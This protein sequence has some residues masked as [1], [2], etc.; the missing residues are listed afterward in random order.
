MTRVLLA[1]LGSYLIG[2]IPTGYWLVKW[3]KRVDVRTLGSG[4][5]GAT[6]VTR[7]AGGGLGKV[8]FVLDAAKGMIAALLIAPMAGPTT[9]PTLALGCGLLAV[10]GH[11]FPVFL[12]F[13]GGKGVATTIG[14]LLATL[15][16]MAAVCGAV[17]LVCFLLGR[18]VSAASVAAAA[19]LPVAQ[20]AARQRPIDILLGGALAALIIMRHRAN[21]QRLLAGTEHRAG[22]AH[23]SD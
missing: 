7:V 17:W 3:I 14:V 10:V 6:N 4:N 16:G 9:E 8:V 5:V 15:P 12:H 22:R 23:H 1:W 20:L 2:S 13:Q 19:A 18:Y 21:I 11:M